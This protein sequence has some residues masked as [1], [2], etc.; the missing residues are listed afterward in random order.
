MSEHRVTIRL[1]EAEHHA[2]KAKAHAAGASV[3]ETI[4]AL[5]QHGGEGGAQ[6]GAIAEVMTALLDR[7]EQLETRESEPP[8]QPDLMPIQRQLVAFAEQQRRTESVLH[9]LL[10]A[11]EKLYQPP[12]VT[13]QRRLEPASQTAEL[14]G[15]KDTA[16]P[17]KRTAPVGGFTS[18]VREQPW[19]H[20]D[21][22]PQ[23][24]ARRL[25]PVYN[26]QFDP[27]HQLPGG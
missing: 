6:V 26:A 16:A 20:N 25:L 21:E 5:I 1:T 15:A 8:A 27:P 10:T 14:P 17:G 12:G 13:T 22:T 9:N 18:W 24:R 19:A 11:V 7:L 23:E 4:R 2:I 3:A